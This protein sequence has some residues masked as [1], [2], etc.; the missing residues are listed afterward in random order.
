MKDLEKG[1]QYLTD[2][3]L[4][5]ISVLDCASLP[6]SMMH[7][8]IA[9][10]VPVADYRRMLLIGH[11][12]P[13][14]WE[15]LQASG[16]KSVDPIDDYSI[17]LTQQF[18][19]DYLSDSPVFWLYPGARYLVPLQQLGETAGWGYPSPLGT[20][21]SPGYGVWYAYRV[22]LLIDAELTL[23]REIPAPSPCISCMKK[24]CIDNCP[25]AAVQQAGFNLA[26]CAQ[27]RLSSRSS[28]AD[29]CTARMACPVH[30]EQRY[31]LKQIQYHYRHSLST[32]R[33]WYGE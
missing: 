7:L 2:K 17:S 5:L 31:T 13:R 11:G 27:H 16:I 25:V 4:N 12:G 8:M 28:C 1:F 23:V 21:I 18:V 22:A 10:G 20:G 15:S 19:R 32:L 29:R 14:M 3:G 26:L 33:D 30:P 24:P 6:A 9:S